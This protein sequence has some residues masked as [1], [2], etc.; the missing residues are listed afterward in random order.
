M[1][2]P[3]IS[4]IYHF[5]VSLILSD[6]VNLQIVPQVQ[7]LSNKLSSKQIDSYLLIGGPSSMTG[8]CN[9]CDKNWC[10]MWGPFINSY[11]VLTMCCPDG[12]MCWWIIRTSQE[13]AVKA[14]SAFILADSWYACWV[15][16]EY[17]CVSWAI[18][19]NNPRPLRKNCSRGDLQATLHKV[20]L[21][22][23]S[24]SSSWQ[25]DYQL[26]AHSHS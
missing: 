24:T 16:L 5:R 20:M 23:Y 11:Q 15:V 3:I 6:L 19:Y 18:H 10:Q 13:W 12:V 2:A 22:T 9:T 21:P 4:V 1:G 8:E 17:L 7:K 14:N 25:W 26:W